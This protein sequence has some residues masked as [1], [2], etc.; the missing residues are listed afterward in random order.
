MWS[1]RGAT[2][3]WGT[4]HITHLYGGLMC[5]RK[6]ANSMKHAPKWMPTLNDKIIDT[7][8]TLNL[9]RHLLLPEW[10]CK[11]WRYVQWEGKWKE[12]G[13][14]NLFILLYMLCSAAHCCVAPNK[15]TKI[16]KKKWHIAT[17]LKL[18]CSSALVTLAGTLVIKMPPSEQLSS[19]GNTH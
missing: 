9:E 16:N 13:G 12:Q 1:S 3:L 5:F 6:E 7:D 4:D 10:L 11:S 8:T 14:Q 15:Q 17:L 2:F 18:L 19:L